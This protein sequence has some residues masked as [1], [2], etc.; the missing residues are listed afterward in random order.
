MSLL[1][2]TMDYHTNSTS[3]QQNILIAI[4]SSSITTTSALAP[5]IPVITVLISMDKLLSPAD[6]EQV[7]NCGYLSLDRKVL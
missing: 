4:M 6:I 1:E 2:S 7:L 3:L 5:R